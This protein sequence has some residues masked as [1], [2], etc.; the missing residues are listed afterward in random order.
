[1]CV[2]VS[3]VICFTRQVLGTVATVLF[4][5]HEIRHTEFQ[6]LPYHRTFIMLLVELNQPEPILEA[7]NF[8]VLQTFRSVRFFIGS[9]NTMHQFLL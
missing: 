1:M 4:Q 2:K 3:F 5:D 9:V 7:I 6:Q 8:Q